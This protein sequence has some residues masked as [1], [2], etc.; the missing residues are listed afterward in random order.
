MTIMKC[1]YCFTRWEKI[2]CTSSIQLE[3]VMY[4]LFM[5]T[6]SSCVVRPIQNNT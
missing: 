6:K 2:L 3:F 5:D 1:I 4:V